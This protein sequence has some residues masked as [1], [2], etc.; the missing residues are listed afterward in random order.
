MQTCKIGFLIVSVGL[1]LVSCRKDNVEVKRS[2][3]SDA[4]ETQAVDKNVETASFADSVKDGRGIA[5]STWADVYS[6][7]DFTKL[8]PKTQQFY[9]TSS[10]TAV[11]I[12]IEPD[13]REILWK[14][15]NFQD[16]VAVT[17]VIAGVKRACN[18]ENYTSLKACL[19]DAIA[20]SG[21]VV[22]EMKQKLGS[23]LNPNDENHIRDALYG[24]LGATFIDSPTPTGGTEMRMTTAC[25]ACHNATVSKN[26]GN[27]TTLFV[28]LRGDNSYSDALAK[29]DIMAS[30]EEFKGY[31]ANPSDPIWATS[32]ETKAAGYLA[33]QYMKLKDQYA[34]QYGY[35]ESDIR[36]NSHKA[37][38]KSVVDSG[39]VSAF[40]NWITTA[41][42]WNGGSMIDDRNI[43][44]RVAIAT[45]KTT[46][47]RILQ[48]RQNLIQPWSVLAPMRSQRSVLFAPSSTEV[49]NR[50]TQAPANFALEYM[51]Y[52]AN[53][54]DPR[55]SALPYLLSATSI[56]LVFPGVEDAVLSQAWYQT[57]PAGADAI[58]KRELPRTIMKNYMVD[59]SMYHQARYIIS[60]PT[61]SSHVQT[62]SLIEADLG[63]TQI[64]NTCFTCHSSAVARLGT[65]ELNAACFGKADCSIRT[66]GTFESAN[67][68]EM[69]TPSSRW[70]QS[71]MVPMETAPEAFKLD[72]YYNV[73]P[74]S[75]IR[76]KPTRIPL[77]R[78]QALGLWTYTSY[79]T[80][81]LP[82]GQRPA[83]GYGIVSSKLSLDRTVPFRTVALNF[84]FDRNG[85]IGQEQM[86]CLQA[87]LFDLDRNGT[88]ETNCFEALRVLSGGTPRP[89]GQGDA[90]ESVH[91]GI[92]NFPTIAA[93]RNA[94]AKMLAAYA[95]GAFNV[96]WGNNTTSYV[97]I[98]PS[99]YE[100]C[101]SEFCQDG[102]WKGFDVPSGEGGS[103][104]GGDSGSSSGGGG[105]TGPIGDF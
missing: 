86:F 95:D 59:A 61:P 97:R 25:S 58:V 83:A 87:Q 35:D 53:T 32:A 4:K 20:K 93:N 43:D 90:I 2:N 54:T 92:V 46:A 28:D 17:D 102:T 50:G 56:S 64:Q 104:P 36:D 49:L 8:H 15:S 23:P 85:I 75:Y 69:E 73:A 77:L 21:A 5:F 88:A 101:A 76:S 31:V 3:P 30:W 34:H 37:N 70:A 47:L 40:A 94:L 71:V 81:L 41:R 96:K 6:K 52:R 82:N 13:R 14:F 29:R 103:S 1:G 72:L 10:Q 45:E 19:D 39:W 62:I 57:T 11:Q 84:D 12:L 24:L 79:A 42:S 33:A 100:S 68:Y 65:A 99:S 63:N 91:S 67:S 38:I 105:G 48:E 74:N 98:V 51:V 80:A 89:I 26:N 55:K 78:R 18:R 66:N 7:I 60:T 27:N 22:F 44:N 16:S 9:Q